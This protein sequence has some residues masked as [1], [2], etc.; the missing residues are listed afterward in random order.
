MNP[1]TKAIA[2]FE[3]R[4]DAIDAGYTEEL[5]EAEADKLKL[6]NRKERR[7]MLAEMRQSDKPVK[8]YKTRK[9]R[10]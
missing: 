2:H 9:P 5:T 6:V 7:R 1:Q 4:Q 10:K 3:T 8:K